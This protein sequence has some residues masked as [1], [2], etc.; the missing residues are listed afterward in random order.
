METQNNQF[1]A[2]NS[3]LSIEFSKYILEH[4]EMDDLLTEETMVVFLPEFDV[5]LRD[6]NLK[7]AKEIK[8]DG[9]KPLYV[10]VKQ[11]ARKVSSRLIGVE[12]GREI[13]TSLTL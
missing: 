4:P 11:M 5:E 12:V 3:E 6:F 13:E 10:K 1:F 7:M 8:S 9:G 2:R